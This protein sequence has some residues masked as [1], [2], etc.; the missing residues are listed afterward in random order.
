MT[1][2]PLDVRRGTLTAPEDH[3]H[4]AISL[5]PSVVSVRRWTI[6]RCCCYYLTGSDFTRLKSY[7]TSARLLPI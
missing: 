2:S 6:Q 4:D 7:K 1:L 5:S 3:V